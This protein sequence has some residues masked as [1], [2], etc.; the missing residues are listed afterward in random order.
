MLFQERLRLT[1]QSLVIAEIAQNHDGSLGMC[2]AYI[3]A[4][5]DVGVHAIKFQTHIASEESTVDEPFRV[6]FSQQDASRYEYWRRMEFTEDQWIGLKTH[7]DE[8]GLEFLSTPFSVAAVEML[9]RIQIPVWKVGSGDTLSGELLTAMLA[10]KRPMIVSTGMSAWAEIDE[11]VGLL[12]KADTEFCLMQCTSMYPTPFPS[13]G[14]NVLDELTQRYGCR[15]GL[16]DHTGSLTPA[17]AAMARGYNLI[18]LHVTFDKRMFGPDISAS[19][20]VN[21][22]GRLMRYSEALQEMNANPVDKDAMASKLRNQ[23]ELFAKSVTLR[24]DR[25]AGHVIE[26]SDIVPKKPGSG[27]PWGDRNQVVGRRLKHQ[28]ASNTLLRREDLE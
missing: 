26:P 11:V 9:E 28:V 20:T 17:M 25:A 16:S 15:V 7:A 14:L 10:T 27:I 1:N 12:R 19:V 18:E 13:V 3:D 8:K 23:K 24:V 5:A 21:E 22:I 6:K 2:H 4:L